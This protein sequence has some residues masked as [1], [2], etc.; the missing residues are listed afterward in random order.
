MKKFEYKTVTST[1]T[2]SFKR[3]TMDAF[4]EELN[5]LGREG[6]ECINAYSPVSK[7][8]DICFLFKR[9]LQD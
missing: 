2:L 6:W 8:M 7:G 3:H 9:E 5:R 4:D 1:S